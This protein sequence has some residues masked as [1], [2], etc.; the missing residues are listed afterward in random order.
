MTG[1]KL[2]ELFVANVQIG[3]GP[4]IAVYLTENRW[5]TAEI[6]YALTIGT[7]CSLVSQVPVGALVDGMRD[8]RWAVWFGTLSISGTALMYALS[9]TQMSVYVAEILHGLASS[10]IGPAIAAVSL[11]LVGRAAFSERIGRN[12]RFASLG[13]GLAA[14]V[15]GAAGSFVSAG[16]V[17]WLT[18]ALGVPALMALRMIG[19]GTGSRPEAEAEQKD[20]TAGLAG[21]KEP[22]LDW[23]LLTFAACVVLFFIS[24]AAMLPLAA[25]QITK[26]HPELADIIIAATIV[27]PQIVVALL[28]PWVGRSSDRLGRRPITLLGWMMLPLQGL[29][30]ASALTPFLLVLG[31]LL[32]G[33]SAAVFGV[34]MTLVAADLT[35]SG[36]FNLTLGS[37]GVA[38]AIGASISTTF[39]GITADAFG[40]SAAFLGLAFAGLVG[41]LLLWLVMPETGVAAAPRRPRWGC[42]ARLWPVSRRPAPERRPDRASR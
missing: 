11:A 2:A 13:S 29:L 19:H 15:M 25:T 21:L 39:A 4:F 1:P 31:Q 5:T 34:T 32:S 37:L 3:F 41:V 17:F 8:K 7:I 40:D 27:I 9:P 18:A 23:R 20:A 28:S 38:I 33:V 24:N 10:V 14:G 36:R 12:A 26:R 42:R 16:S 6:G 22:F 35:G 30:Y